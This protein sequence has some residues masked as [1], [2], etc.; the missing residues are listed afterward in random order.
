MTIPAN[1]TTEWN[2]VQAQVIAASPLANASY[3]TIKAIQL[4]AGNLVADIQSALVS[5]STLDSWSAPSDPSSIITGFE[6]VVEAA[7]DQSDL[8]LLRGIAGRAASNL[9]QLV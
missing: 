1:I 4:N 7:D 2:A 9:D 8:S 6:A 5:T 3:A